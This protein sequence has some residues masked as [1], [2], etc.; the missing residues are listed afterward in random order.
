MPC[1][2]GKPVGSESGA[3]TSEF[4]NIVPAKYPKGEGENSEVSNYDHCL[5]YLM[6]ES[7]I[8]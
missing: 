7:A 6:G 3:Q 1:P 8:L 4:F 5:L 2:P